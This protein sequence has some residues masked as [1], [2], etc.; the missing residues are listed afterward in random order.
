[1]TFKNLTP[2]T[3]FGYIFMLLVFLHDRHGVLSSLNFIAFQFICIFP[4]FFNVFMLVLVGVH[5]GH[6]QKLQSATDDMM[7]SKL[8]MFKKCRCA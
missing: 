6:L 2:T 8:L 1:M 4:M 5:F 7:C 3:G